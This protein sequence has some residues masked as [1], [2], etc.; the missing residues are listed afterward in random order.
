MKLLFHSFVVHH[1]VV[2]VIKAEEAIIGIRPN[3]G[4]LPE[5]SARRADADP[6]ADDAD[7]SHL[8]KMGYVNWAAS[9][10]TTTSSIGECPTPS[11]SAPPT[12]RG[13]DRA[14]GSS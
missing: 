4:I 9:T 13:D 12:H 5:I 1:V 3:K 6:N 11:L 8:A 10:T 2:G 14:V 7:T